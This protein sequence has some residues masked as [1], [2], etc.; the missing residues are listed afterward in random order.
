MVNKVSE[1]VV[2]MSKIRQF[3]ASRIGRFHP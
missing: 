3:V 2:M 1:A